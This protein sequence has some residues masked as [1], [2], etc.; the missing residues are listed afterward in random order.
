MIYRYWWL[1]SDVGQFTVVGNYF[2][3]SEIIYRYPEMRKECSFE[4]P[5]IGVL[6]QN[7]KMD[8]ILS[9]L[10]LVFKYKSIQVLL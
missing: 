9:D 1:F 3:V 2:P 5:L 7:R 8:I 6:Q 10:Y 4:T